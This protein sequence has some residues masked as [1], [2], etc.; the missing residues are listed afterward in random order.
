VAYHDLASYYRAADVFVSPTRA[1]TWGVAVLEAMAFGKPV[2]CSKYAGSREMIV[3]GEN[4]FIFDPFNADQLASFMTR[5]IQ[6]KNLIARFGACSLEKIAPYTP[7][8]AAAVLADVAMATI[9]P[10]R[11]S[12]QPEMSHN[13]GSVPPHK[14]RA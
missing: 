6:D 2:L 14:A 10:Q 12:S 7:A 11:H 8:R 13:S 9:Q 5:F 1:D 3:P 4:G